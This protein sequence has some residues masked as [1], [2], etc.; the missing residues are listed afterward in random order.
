LISP[1]VSDPAGL[2]LDQD[3]DGI[4]GVEG[5]DDYLV[6]F[7]IFDSSP[8]VISSFEIPIEISGFDIFASLLT[9]D[10]ELR[11]IA[12]LNLQLNLSFPSMGSL[13]VWLIS[14][15]GTGK[16]A[17]LVCKDEFPDSLLSFSDSCQ[18]GES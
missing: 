16:S 12:D 11:P 13:E 5:S 1:H 6:S 3:G 9:I 15:A 8:Q 14:P 17:S 4:G 2:E 18:H 7:E 10:E